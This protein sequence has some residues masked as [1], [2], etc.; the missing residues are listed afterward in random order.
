MWVFLGLVACG[1]LWGLVRWFGLYRCHPD[2]LRYLLPFGDEGRE[3]RGA[4]HKKRKES[5]RIR[6]DADVVFEAA[7]LAAEGSLV[8]FIER[9]DELR[10]ERDT[11][12]ADAQKPGEAVGD[13]LGPTSGPEEW[14][15]L[16]EHVLAS[17]KRVRSETGE[18]ED[19]WGE[20]LFLAGLDIE[21]RTDRNHHICLRVTLP[22]GQNRLREW[23]YPDTADWEIRLN[24]FVRLAREQIAQEYDFRARLQADEAEN[25]KAIRKAEAEH[26]TAAET[27]ARKIGE[28]ERDRKK[29]HADADVVRDEAY[30][31]WVDEG[32]GLRPWW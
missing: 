31:L 12:H 2:R 21:T 19:V 9:L 14:L 23:L 4:L 5:N 6:N 10:G 16:H 11:L 3:A 13:L 24:V 29:G 30:D 15:Q 18:T 8:P 27:A 26:R 25:T 32:G 28:A 22:G 1:V 17:L 7:R 20:P